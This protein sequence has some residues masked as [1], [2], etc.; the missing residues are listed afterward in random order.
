ME[1]NPQ[2]Q[3][4]GNMTDRVKR[5]EFLVEAYSATLYRYAYWLTKDAGAAEDL[6]QDTFLRAWRFMDNLQEQAAAKSWLITILRRENARKYERKALDMEDREVD[7]LSE[8]TI[9][10][11]VSEDEFQFLQRAIAELPLKYREPL[12]LQILEGFSLDEI[13]DICDLPRNTVAT[14]IHRARQQLIKLH[15]GRDSARPVP[16]GKML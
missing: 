6:V 3:V 8:I 10:S 12:A 4:Y 1:E 2:S 15:R 11:R 13:S 9:S 7:D 5:Y 14:R 16:S